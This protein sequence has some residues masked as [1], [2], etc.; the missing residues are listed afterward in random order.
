MVQDFYISGQKQTDPYLLVDGKK[1]YVFNESSHQKY[2]PRKGKRILWYESGNKLAETNYQN[3]IENGTW[4][5][6][7]ENGK[8]KEE[9]N[10]KDGQLNGIFKSW[11][12]DGVILGECNY[13][14]GIQNGRC[15]EKYTI[16]PKAFIYDGRYNN[17]KK[18]GEW[19]EWD[20]EGNLIN[21]EKYN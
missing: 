21:I 13:Q 2:Y 20:E 6:W 7:Y 14:L 9:I 4:K 8:L 17:G 15:Y 11:S 18:V 1:D 3:N 10:Y 16:N 5:T 12:E 19:K